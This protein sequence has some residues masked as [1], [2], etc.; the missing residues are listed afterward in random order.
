[1]TTHD[2]FS[3]LSEPLNQHSRLERRPGVQVGSFGNEVILFQPDSLMVC[4][5]DEQ[6]AGIW[7]RCVG[8]PFSELIESAGRSLG[9][10]PRDIIELIRV[11]RLFEMIG[12]SDASS[13]ADEAGTLLCSPI[14]RCNEFRFRGE[15]RDSGELRLAI[16]GGS[17]EECTVVLGADSGEDRNRSPFTIVIAVSVEETEREIQG[18]EAIT[19]LARRV[20]ESGIDVL[21]RVVATHRVLLQQKAHS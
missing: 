13:S 1:M 16:I 6:A 8:Q 14:P 2:R 10:E 3:G 20:P 5:L 21:I 9:T 17:E 12:D 4:I 19:E 7:L 18:L 11:L 15:F